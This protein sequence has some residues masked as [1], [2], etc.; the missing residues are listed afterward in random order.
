MNAKPD[1]FPNQRLFRLPAELARRA[2]ELPLCRDLTVTDTGFFPETTGHRVTRPEGSSSGI[3]IF[4]MGGRGWVRADGGKLDLHGGE[5]LWIPAG[6]PHAYGAH[7][8]DPW[9]LYW[10]HLAGA[11]LP[12]WECWIRKGE[13]RPI[14]WRV[15]D[16]T[17]LAERF[18]SLWRRV[19]DGGTDLSLL[20]MTAEA[21]ALMAHAVASRGPADA[22]ARRLEE[23]IDRGVLWMREHLHQPVRLADCARAAGM[24]PSHYS[25]E[26]RRVTGVPPLKYFNR[27]RLRKAS[28]WLDADDTPIQEI[29]DRLGYANPFHF[30][31]AFRG[32]TGLSPRAYRKRLSGG[33]P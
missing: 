30:S 27:L 33:R 32:F 23:R 3:L 16:P 5:V 13:A 26:F 17:G 28:E 4:C 9:R 31:K 20:R 14:R 12:A 15:N 19:D 10:L 21:Q 24:S 11:G 7:P 22:R 6:A 25:A 29:A 18:E 2:E 8:N 1:G